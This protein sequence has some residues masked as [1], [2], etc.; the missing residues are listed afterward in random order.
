MPVKTNFLLKFFVSIACHN[1]SLQD[2]AK[3][4]KKVQIAVCQI[5]LFS[6]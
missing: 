3:E 2:L 6:L 1:M 5:L 4:Q